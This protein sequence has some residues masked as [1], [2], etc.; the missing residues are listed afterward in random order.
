MSLRRERTAVIIIIAGIRKLS[1]S[2]IMRHMT[3]TVTPVIAGM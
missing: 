1:K 3:D 2:K